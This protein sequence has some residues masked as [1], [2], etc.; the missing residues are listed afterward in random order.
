MEV[1]LIVGVIGIAT[2]IAKRARCYVKLSDNMV[3]GFLEK[4][5]PVKTIFSLTN[6]SLLYIGHKTFLL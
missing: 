1:A 6:C 4:P 2:I 3:F 5:L